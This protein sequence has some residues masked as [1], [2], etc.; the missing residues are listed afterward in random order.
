[1]ISQ[2]SKGT[3][4]CTV[5]Q[6]S[7]V[8]AGELAGIASTLGL[9]ATDPAWLGASVVLSGITDFRHAPPSS[10]LQAENRM[11]LVVDMQSRP[12]RF[13]ALTIGKARPGAGRDFVAAAEGPR[14]HGLG[15]TARRSED[16]RPLAAACSGPTRLGPGSREIYGFSA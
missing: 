12:C 16:R 3:E 8:S 13:P 10:R 11:T 6:V 5:R 14:G 1:V 9:D 4:I 2:H 15:G 7:V